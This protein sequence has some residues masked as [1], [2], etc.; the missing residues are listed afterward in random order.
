MQIKDSDL[1]MGAQEVYNAKT[2]IQKEVIDSM[3]TIQALINHLKH[4]HKS[5]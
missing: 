2:Q 4:E 1:C 3:T 5:A